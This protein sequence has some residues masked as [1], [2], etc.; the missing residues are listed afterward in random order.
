MKKKKVI[1]SKLKDKIIGGILYSTSTIGLIS[2]ANGTYFEGIKSLTEGIFKLLMF[3]P[4]VI[5]VTVTI[6]IL[7][8]FIADM[9]GIKIED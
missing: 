5:G 7:L 2:I 8:K 4:I 3:F 6:C 9:L 1:S